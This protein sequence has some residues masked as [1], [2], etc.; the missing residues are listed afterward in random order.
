VETKNWFEHRA[1]LGLLQIEEMSGLGW[2]GLG[3]V[4]LKTVLWKSS[5]EGGA[6]NLLWDI[7]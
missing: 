6:L 1:V 4:F 3:L 5:R 2:D 7:V